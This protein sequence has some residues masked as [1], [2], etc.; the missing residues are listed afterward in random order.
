MKLKRLILENV[1]CYKNITL[2]FDFYNDENEKNSIR[3]R[4][5]ILGNNGTGKTTILKSI[6]L[7][8]SGSSAL[9]ELIGNP[10]SWIHAKAD[11]CHI[12]GIL[13]LSPRYVVVPKTVKVVTIDI[14]MELG[15]LPYYI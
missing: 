12:K 14:A 1:R 4:T 8:L 5:I 10:D 2:D 9:G 6:A 3:N 7:L 15:I 13:N 11:S